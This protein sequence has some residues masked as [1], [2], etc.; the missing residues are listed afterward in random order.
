MFDSL[1]SKPTDV[2]TM[3]NHLVMTAGLVMFHFSH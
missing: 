1:D 3:K 2:P